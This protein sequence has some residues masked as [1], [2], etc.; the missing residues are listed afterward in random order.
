LYGLKLVGFLLTNNAYVVVHYL[1]A[2]IEIAAAGARKSK[3]SRTFCD[4]PELFTLINFA[5]TSWEL[6]H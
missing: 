2:V 3:A 6:L 5:P 4:F 1:C